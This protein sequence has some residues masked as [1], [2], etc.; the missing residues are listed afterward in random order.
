[1]ILDYPACDRVTSAVEFPSIGR[2]KATFSSSRWPARR[3]RFANPSSPLR[4]H[5]TFAVVASAAWAFAF[6]Y[7]ALWLINCVTSVR[8]D[9]ETEK[10][11][12]DA[13]LLGDAAYSED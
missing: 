3:K 11:E 8:V 7:A 5:P 10:P 9:A 4:S 2:P 1:M 13:R 6:S 12:L